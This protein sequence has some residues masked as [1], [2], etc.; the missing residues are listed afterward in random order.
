[1]KIVKDYIKCSY[2]ALEL[3]I[4]HDGVEHAGYMAF[5]S[6]LSIFPFAVF[7]IKIAGFL[8]D[9]HIGTDFIGALFTHLPENLIAS[10]KPRISEITSSTPNGILTISI[11]GIIWTAS[12]SVE[13]LRTILNRAYNIKS[14]PPYLRRRILSILQFFLLSATI[15]VVMFVLVFLPAL[16]EIID[17]FLQQNNLLAIRGVI[18]FTNFLDPIWSNFRFLI[19][20][21][22]MLLA[23]NIIYYIIPNK[24][25]NFKAQLPGSILV[26]GLWYISAKLLTSYVSNYNQVNLVYGSLG[27]IIATLL[28]FYIA[29]LIFIYGA[30]FN[31]I[32]SSRII[33][34]K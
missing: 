17:L 13:G 19:V 32:L 7:I 16:Y 4:I 14:P 21:V 12:S 6:I 20:I 9:S 11:F 10:I 24:K 30:E 28:F 15:I 34:R 2:K 5:L 31:Y 1:M 3:T 27:G 8:G 25:H 18:K 26:V 23:V 29:N 22:T 33:S